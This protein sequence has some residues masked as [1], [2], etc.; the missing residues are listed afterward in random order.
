MNSPM[1][2]IGEMWTKIVS[3]QETQ[4]NLN[5]TATL[6]DRHWPFSLIRVVSAGTT[7]TF[8]KQLG[9]GGTTAFFYINVSSDSF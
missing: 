1:L 6:S 8:D 2:R 7:S 4:P 3:D 9:L 5:A